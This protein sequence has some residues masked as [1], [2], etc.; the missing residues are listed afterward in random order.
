[1]ALKAFQIMRQVGGVIYLVSLLPGLDITD[2][3]TL[4]A[5]SCI[6]LTPQDSA[7]FLANKPDHDIAGSGEMGLKFTH[8]TRFGMA[9]DAFGH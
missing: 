7:P 8:Y 6:N 9:I 1:M 5:S 4:N 3:M 2:F